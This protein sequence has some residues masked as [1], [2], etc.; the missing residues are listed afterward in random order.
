MFFLKL[1]PFVSCLRNPGHEGVLCIFSRSFILSTFCIR[2]LIHHKFILGGVKSSQCSYF[3]FIDRQLTVPFNAKRY[4]AI[5]IVNQTATYVFF[6]GFSCVI[7]LLM[8]PFVKTT[9]DS[10]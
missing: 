3:P 1:V 6:S 9:F 8:Y 7:D 5:F 10:R 4:R 2:S